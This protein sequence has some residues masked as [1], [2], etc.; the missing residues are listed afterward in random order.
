MDVLCLYPNLKNQTH[1]EG[2]LM[3]QVGLD[4]LRISF[5]PCL[6][7]ELTFTQHSSRSILPNTLLP[8]TADQSMEVWPRLSQGP[9]GT[10]E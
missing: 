10:W 9:A 6:P 4:G 5:R 8:T 7:S 2:S 1:L 3:G